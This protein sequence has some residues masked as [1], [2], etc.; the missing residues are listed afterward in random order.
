MLIELG[1]FVLNSG[2]ESEF[3]L[4]ADEFIRENLEGL[5]HLLRK[6]VGPFGA[7]HG[8]PRGGCLLAEALDKHS[9]VELPQ[10]LLIVDDVLTTGGSMKRAREQKAGEREY[11]VGAVVFSRGPCPGWITP[12]FAMP[13]SLWLR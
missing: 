9:C 10:T 12:L 1:K 5:V 6:A 3:K 2:K 8:I 7:V 11:I 13:G 4:I